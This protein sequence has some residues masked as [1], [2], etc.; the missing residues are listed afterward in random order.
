MVMFCGL[1][2]ASGT[3]GYFYLTSVRQS[4]HATL[5]LIRGSQLVVIRHGRVDAEAV[6]STTVLNEGDQVLTGADTEANV[7]LFDGSTLH[8]FFDSKTSLPTLRSSRFFGN[9]KEITVSNDQGTSVLSTAPADPGV[10]TVYEITTPQAE[11]DV[12]ADTTVRTQV[13]PT[14]QADGTRVA[15]S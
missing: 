14:N 2:A 4:E 12:D 3:F 13:G 10:T 9:R 5:Q 15:V 6:A 7:D 8:V 1:C 11:I